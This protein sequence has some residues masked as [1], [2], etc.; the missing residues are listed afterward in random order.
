MSV[1]TKWMCHMQTGLELYVARG[2]L[3]LLNLFT[4]T[5]PPSSPPL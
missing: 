5:T 4:T 3:E 1:S 2:N